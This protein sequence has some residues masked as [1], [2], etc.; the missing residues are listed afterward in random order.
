MKVCQRL[1]ENPQ[2][3][4]IPIVFVSAHED[5]RKPDPRA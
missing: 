1:K 5:S 3:K 4:D 2:T